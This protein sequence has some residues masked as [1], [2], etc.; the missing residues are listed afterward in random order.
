MPST[1]GKLLVASP[2][3]ADPNFLRAVLLMIQHSEQGAMGL[4]LNRPLPMTVREACQQSVG[5]AC[6]V[7]GVLHQG[8]PCEGPLMA[9]HASELAKDPEVLP[10]VFFTTER[11]KLESLLR[12][13]NGQE[14]FFV[15]YAGWAPGQ[16]EAEMEIES[17]L[18]VPADPRIVFESKSNLWSK[19]MTQRIIGKQFD[20]S[21]IP[22]DPS[23]N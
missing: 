2:R 11:S 20:L 8:G 10:G 16:L 4:I 22:D 1:Q 19:L 18:V 12:Q 21:R 6:A 14:R 17:W 23:V 13:P 15:G 3:L 7:E 9:L 5:E